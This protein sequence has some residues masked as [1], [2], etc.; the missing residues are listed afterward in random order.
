MREVRPVGSNTSRPVDIRVVAAT[1]RPLA[2]SV[3]R[4]TFREDLYYRL[5]VV[6]LVLPP[7]RVRQ[8]DLP[9]LA[10][11]FWERFAG[12]SMAFPNDLVTAMHGRSWPGNVRELR[13]FVER[14]VTLGWAQ[15]RAE[16]GRE[17]PSPVGLDTIVPTHL[18]LSDAR[19]AWVDQFE[20]LYVSAMLRKTGGNVSRAA[21]LA[22]VTRRSFQRA[23]ARVGIRSSDD[24]SGS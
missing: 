5:A 14:S 2:Q 20:T 23:M 22:S 13:N 24:G 18:P 4:G 11:H 3:N 17:K 7:L 21:E 9:T 8:G 10:R 6:E 1:N 12:E 16:S 19:K 15:G